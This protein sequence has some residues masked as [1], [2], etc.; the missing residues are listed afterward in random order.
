MSLSY[1]MLCYS[2]HYTCFRYYSHKVF[3]V[4]LPG[5]LQVSVCCYW[6]Q[7]ARLGC[8]SNNV[9]T[10]VTPGLLQVS[11]FV[12]GLPLV[13]LNTLCPNQGKRNKMRTI[14]H[15]GLNKGFWFWHCK[16]VREYKERHPKVAGEYYG[17]SVVNITT[18]VSMPVWIRKHIIWQILEE[19]RIVE[20]LK[21][22]FLCLI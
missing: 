2:D 4:V 9:S 16:K 5:P 21:R 17:R 11:V 19:G 10:V 18:K 1:D 8:N 3:T 7:H 13:I 15:S 14:F 6:D 20:R 22:C 12:I